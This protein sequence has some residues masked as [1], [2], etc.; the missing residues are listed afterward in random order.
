MIVGSLYSV[1][2]NYIL[3]N[4]TEYRHLCNQFN[5]E[6]FYVRAHFDHKPTGDGELSFRRDDIML[7]ENTLYDGKPDNWYA[8]LVDDDGHKLNYKGIIPSQDK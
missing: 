3:T 1:I 4:F 6:S 2:W 5:S 7:I 8:W